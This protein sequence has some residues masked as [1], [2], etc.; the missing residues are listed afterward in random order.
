MNAV[1]LL[2]EHGF[3]VGLQLMPGLPGDTTIDFIRK[4]IDHVVA[5]KPGFV[6]L[7]PLLVIKGTPLEKLYR[8]GGYRPLTLDEA[9]ALCCNASIKLE[10]AG[11]DVIRIGLQATEELER[12]GTVIAGPF[13]PAFRQLVESAIFLDK[14]RSALKKRIGKNKTAEFSVNPKDLSSAIGQ[15]RENIKTLIKEFKLEKI[16]VVEDSGVQGKREMKLSST[17]T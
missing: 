16:R 2:K 13:H 5:I 10:Q 6:R 11:I 17:S 4:T 12:P 9:V 1:K 3:E 15:R 8:N 14:M 7:Y